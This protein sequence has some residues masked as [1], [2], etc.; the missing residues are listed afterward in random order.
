MAKDPS[1]SKPDNGNKSRDKEELFNG[2]ASLGVLY[3]KEGQYERAIEELEKAVVINPSS[4]E[5][6]ANLG[7][8]FLM[9]KEYDK[10]GEYLSRAIA[11]NPS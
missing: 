4:P 9:I 7:Y 6:F 1:L 2:H 11:L 10:A 3:A 8:I 5:I